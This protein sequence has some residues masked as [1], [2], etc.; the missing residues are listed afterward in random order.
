MAMG[1]VVCLGLL[2]MLPQVLGFSNSGPWQ[3]FLRLPSDGTK[4]ALLIAGSKGYDNYRHQADLCHAY[5]IVKRGGLKDENIVVMMYDDIANNPS[6]PHKGVIINKPKGGNVYPGVPKD[7]TGNN[8]NKKNFLAVLLGKKSALTGA[9]NG[10]VISSG[11]SDNVFV[12]YTDHGG[13]GV[14]SMPSGEGLYAKELVNALKDKR[15]ARG[16]KNLVIYVEACESGSIFQGLLP[17]NIGVYAMTASNPT[18]DSYATY[19]PGDPKDPPPP[20][21]KTCLGDL[22]SVAWMEDTD[23]HK[24]GETLGQQYDIVKKR[25]TKSPVMRYGDLSLS[26]QPINNF[27]LPAPTSPATTSDAISTTSG[28]SQRDAELVYLWRNYEESVE[29]SAEKVE[30]RERLLREMERRSRLD[31]S[32]ELIGDL[33]LGV[34]GSSK[35][36]IPRPEEQPLVDDWDCLKSMVRTFEAHCGQLGHYGMKHMRAFANMC[37]AAVDHHDMAKAASKACMH[38]VVT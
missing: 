3:E 17:S 32:V 11:P 25:T 9:G 26:N 22:F 2:L 28:V 8:V 29:G 38:P 20:E 16:F 13:P 5:Q 35:L 36:M 31:R 34:S 24:P 27:Y 33:L 6:N 7:Y 1:S 14:L 21:Y 19:C 4:W 12:Y 15:A 23:L 10:K 37:N 30:A 18:K